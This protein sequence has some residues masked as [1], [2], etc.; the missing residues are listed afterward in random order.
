MDIDTWDYTADVV[1]VG[2]GGAGACAA[3][4]ASRAGASVLA[5]EAASTGGGTTA[6]AGGQIY[7]GGGTAVQRACNVE[8]SVDDMYSYLLAAAGKNADKDKIRVYCDTS[9]EHFNWLVEQ[10]LTFRNEL[11]KRKLPNTPGKEGLIYS[12]NERS[13][14]YLDLAKP[15]PRGHKAE[16]EGEEGGALL[17]ATLLQRLAETDCS[18]LYDSRART[19]VL[20]EENSVA[21]VVAR[22][23]G[24]DIAIRA[25]KGVILCAGG[26][27]M[28]RDMI[29]R[30]APKLRRCNYPIGNPGDNGTGIRLGMGAG[31]A[32]I[33]LHE[34]L[35]SIPFY[36]PESFV[37]GIFINSQGQRF[38]AEDAYHG[39]VGDAIL[40]QPHSRIFL[41]VDNSC[42]DKP[43][44]SNISLTAAGDT[45]QELESELELPPGSLVHTMTQYNQWASEGKDPLFHKY[46][47]Y[48]RPLDTGPYAA[49]ECT[50]GS[51]ALFCYFT[52][53]GLDTTIDGE[54]RNA[55]GETIAGL[56][57]AGRTACGVPR[58]GAEYASGTAIGDATLFGRR[59]GKAAA[60]R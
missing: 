38:V 7:L 44:L 19:L 22:A 12:G 60:N 28:N 59:A 57:A 33:N 14:P 34:G 20:D 45:I 47:D 39:K 51:G 42:Y 58:S 41:I 30:Y 26:F 1:I 49:F 29:T 48:L 3:L 6:L 13:H 8:D 18:V 2:L 24:R 40:N 46:P 53:G 15:A 43:E 55:D 32:A 31:G 17:M 50:P 16:A 36:P 35:T 37:Y 9:V 21:G 56:Y 52:L 11:V 5:L 4:E 23:S 10:G 54:V 25:T 27:A